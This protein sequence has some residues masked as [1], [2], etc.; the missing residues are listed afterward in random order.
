MNKQN[1]SIEETIN[2]IKLRGSA[3][4]FEAAIYLGLSVHYVRRLARE[5]EIS[6]N[7][8][9]GKCIYFKVEDL[10]DYLLSNNRISNKKIM[11][12]TAKYLFYNQ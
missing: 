6:S 1:L 8:P 4:T 10:D 9:K 5:N 3:N 11:E 7:K 12:K 2:I